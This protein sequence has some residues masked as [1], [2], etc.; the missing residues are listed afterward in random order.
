MLC[1]YIPNRKRPR[2]ILKDNPQH[3]I[4]FLTF[5]VEKE[6]E[7]TPF[8]LPEFIINLD[9]GRKIEKKVRNFLLPQKF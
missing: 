8:S 7:K 2:I 9:W 3:E 1:V 6:K 5:N 4:K